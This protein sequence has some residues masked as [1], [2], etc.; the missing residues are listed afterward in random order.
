MAKSN[1]KPALG[2]GL[3]A[4]LNDSDNVIN[5]VNDEHAAQV[6]GNIID[7][8]LDKITTNPFQ[9]R[10]YFNEEALDELSQ[11]IQYEKS[12]L[13]MIKMRHTWRACQSAAFQSAIFPNCNFIF[14]TQ[15]C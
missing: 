6:I 10:T 9:P 1:R 11:S 2:R 15:T 8:E 14:D 12:G 7:L 5:S 4:L 13:L 3:S